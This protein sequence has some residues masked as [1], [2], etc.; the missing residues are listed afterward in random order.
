VPVQFLLTALVAVLVVVV[1]EAIAHP[2]LL[3][4][5][6]LPVRA[7]MAVT[8]TVAEVALALLVVAVVPVL[9]V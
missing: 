8:V 2:R 6:A 7:M 3:E 5:L 9:P 4:G 1:V